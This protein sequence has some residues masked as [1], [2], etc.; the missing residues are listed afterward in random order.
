MVTKHKYNLTIATK[1]IFIQ[2]FFLLNN[3]CIFD[4]ELANLLV[5]LFGF[6]SVT[7]TRGASI[8]LT[9]RMFRI[10]WESIRA[11]KKIKL[12]FLYYIPMNDDTVWTVGKT[13][14][15]KSYQRF[16]KTL[17]PINVEIVYTSCQYCER[18]QQRTATV[19]YNAHI[20]FSK[21]SL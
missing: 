15:A 19:V 6:H 18:K 17:D 21:I 10:F 12:L 1:I 5:A 8:G 20:K 9:G 11:L 16:H 13:A 2:Y 14:W 4:N 7:T 3:R